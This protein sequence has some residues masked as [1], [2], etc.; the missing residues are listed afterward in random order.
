MEFDSQ[1]GVIL[2]QEVPAKVAP[3]LTTEIPEFTEKE[4]GY[5]LRFFAKHPERSEWAVGSV[6]NNK[7]AHEMSRSRNSS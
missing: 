1:H 2:M 3:V 6:V 7:K 5:G 4:Q